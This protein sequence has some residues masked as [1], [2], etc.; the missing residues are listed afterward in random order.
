MQFRILGP[1][2]VVGSDGPVA[3]G[4]TKQRA[5]L[6]FLLLQANRVVATSQL[7]NAL[8]GVDDAPTTGR[9]ILQNAVYSLRGIL[10]GGRAAGGESATLLTRPPGYMMRVDPEQVDMYLF[11]KWV[12]QGREKQAEGAVEQAAALLR[13]ALALWRGPVLADLVE[14]GIDW[15][16][17]GALQSLRL[18]AME[19]YFDAEL[20]CGRHSTVLAELETISQAEPL[21][22]RSCAQLMLALYRCGRQADALNAYSRVRSALV[23]ELGLEPGRELQR[24]QRAI[25]TQ[26]P[27]LSQTRTG[28]GDVLREMAGEP[29]RE[30]ELVAASAPGAREQARPRRPAAPAAQTP[31]VTAPASGNGGAAAVRQPDVDRRRVSV[32]AVRT[33]MA[34]SLSTGVREDRD[35][36][37]DGVTL[38]VGEQIERFGGT[39]MASM[40]SV[41]LALF[42]VHEPADDDARQ[43]VLAGLAI[44]DALDVCD[45]TGAGHARFSV[46][47]SVSMG[48]VLLRRRGQTATPTVVG[49]VL[50]ESQSLLQGVPAGE[51][52]VNDAIRR[53]T[54]NTIVYHQADPPSA[55]WRA[56]GAWSE[57]P[58]GRPGGQD[59]GYELDVLHGLVKRTRHR[60][61]PHLITVLGGPGTGKSRMLGDFGHLIAS[62]P[63]PTLFLAGRAPTAPHED[64]LLA[65][66]QTL[67]AYCG[68]RPADDVVVARAALAAKVRALF[69]DGPAASRHLAVLTPLIETVAGARAGAGAAEDVLDAW[70]GFFQEAARRVPLVLCV[71]DLHRADDAVLRA[72][73]ELAESARSG[74]LVVIAAASPDLLLRRPTW[75]GGKSH[76]TTVTLD[77]PA[78]ITT[79][80]LVEFLLS[81]ARSERPKSPADTGV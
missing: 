8:W 1:L 62:Q 75:A 57:T 59:R 47:V 19:D 3:L 9:K 34:P 70:C 37:M 63:E 64:P 4:G 42:G 21:R 49:G 44:R 61:V 24:F 29:V 32:V 69:A 52:R 36:L 56:I 48:Q 51:V 60:S 26:D 39:V 43:A 7:L 58:D 23:E 73:E 25:L 45:E 74:S 66:A 78:R 77:P 55:G 11:H 27:A 50:D 33:W 79:E 10:A 15:P 12:R 22:E 68:V 54:E 31:R 35:D 17:L 72:V 5:T 30:P 16:E 28:A 14:V 65:Q 81:A 38:V 53:A 18:D 6:G 71:D 80:Q 46:H 76:A 41:S 20:A 13:D 40:G 2:E 67:A